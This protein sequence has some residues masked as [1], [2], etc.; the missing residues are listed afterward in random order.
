MSATLHCP[1][2]ECW[3]ALF[4]GDLPPDQRERCE[5]HLESCPVCQDSLDRAEEHGDTLRTLG[6]Q[7]GDPTAVPADPTLTG[8]LERLHD[9][10]DSVRSG[11]GS[12]GLSTVTT[13]LSAQVKD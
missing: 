11:P 4:S 3:Q 1:G 8:V 13:G 10:P 9:A 5:R 2:T 6:R 12:P 7:V